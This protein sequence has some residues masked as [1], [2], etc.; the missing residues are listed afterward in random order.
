MSTLNTDAANRVIR[1]NRSS[2]G[3]SSNAVRFNASNLEAS[4]AGKSGEFMRISVY[5]VYECKP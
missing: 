3:E 4:S 1:S 5:T 2:G